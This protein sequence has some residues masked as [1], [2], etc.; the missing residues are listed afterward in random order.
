MSECAGDPRSALGVTGG[1][2]AGAGA[3]KWRCAALQLSCHPAMNKLVS[4]TQWPMLRHPSPHQL[5]YKVAET[6]VDNV[7][8]LASCEPMPPRHLFVDISDVFARL[9]ETRDG[10]FLRETVNLF[11]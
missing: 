1:G 3:I 9:L 2:G 6:K 7:K 10:R 5:N 11:L 8:S 4:A